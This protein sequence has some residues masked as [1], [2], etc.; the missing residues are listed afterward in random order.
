MGREREEKQRDETY[1]DVKAE[2]DENG[3]VRVKRGWGGG[4][5]CRVMG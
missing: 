3:R 5:G 2:F 1:N 4:R